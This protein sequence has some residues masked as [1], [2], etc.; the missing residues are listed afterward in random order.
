MNSDECNTAP[1][2]SVILPVYNG[3]A[4][5]ASAIDSVLNQT[6]SNFE[7]IIIDDGSTDNSLS[8]LREYEKIDRRIRLSSR[9]NAGL[10]NTLNE[11]IALAT[12]TW[13]ARMDQDDIAISTRF[14]KQLEYL[15]YSGADI[16][17][18]WVKRFGT[19]DKRIVKLPESDSAIKIALLFIS[20]FAHPTVMMR[21]DFVKR[22][23]YRHKWDKAEDYDLWVRAAICG[24]K[25]ANVPEVLLKYRVHTTQISTSSALR[26]LNLSRGI[27][28]NYW[29]HLLTQWGCDTSCVSSVVNIYN[30][31]Y[32]VSVE[33]VDMALTYVLQHSEKE[34]H[35]MIFKNAFRM[36]IRIAADHPNLAERWKKL[37]NNFSIV[38]SKK[39]MVTIKI[40]CFFR[41]RP[42]GKFFIG[43]RR[44]LVFLNFR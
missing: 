12:G 29:N 15:N 42:E 13:I 35:E 43:A 21:A 11:S 20:P 9:V 37:C 25:M 39:S 4:H 26:Q 14:E 16:V 5:L 28:E 36:Y 38:P 6:V 31:G 41:I 32:K 22:L 18:S 2:I 3:A 44:A 34:T 7:L 23:Q 17:G 40:L 8:I 27:Q 24:W 30:S 33:D 1:L 10:A 19:T